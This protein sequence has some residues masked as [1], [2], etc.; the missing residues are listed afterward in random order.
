M[1]SS[2]SHHHLVL[3]RHKYNIAYRDWEENAIKLKFMQ[4]FCCCRNLYL[5]QGR[6]TASKSNWRNS[7]QAGKVLDINIWTMILWIWWD[8]NTLTY[9]PHARLTPH[10]TDLNNSIFQ[11]S[12]R[13]FIYL[14]DDAAS[15]Y[16]IFGTILLS[17]LLDWYSRISKPRIL[18]CLICDFHNTSHSEDIEREV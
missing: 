1:W 3:H 9:L 6:P 8:G 10:E 15:K 11:C 18:F 7:I 17:K 4:R 5:L 16:N 14:W 13:F 12:K 2:L